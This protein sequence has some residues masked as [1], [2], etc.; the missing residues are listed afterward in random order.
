MKTL[1]TVVELEKRDKEK[2]F[3]TLFLPTW[4]ITNTKITVLNKK[5]TSSK[6]EYLIMFQELV[7]HLLMTE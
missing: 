3:M 6:E 5:S 7:T 1:S 4:L 2:K